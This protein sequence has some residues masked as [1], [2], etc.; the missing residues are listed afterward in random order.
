V[1]RTLPEY[2]SG[3]KR[4]LGKITKT[5]NSH[6]RRLLIESAWNYRHPARLCPKLLKRQEG[7]PAAVPDI[8]WRAQVRLTRRYRRLAARGLQYNKNYVAIARELAGFIWSIGRQVTVGR[9]S[10][11]TES[12]R[13][14]MS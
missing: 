14:L 2:S 13:V 3:E 10:L 11:V 4:A 8:A 5:G 7:Q 12:R 6:A 9:L 1:Q